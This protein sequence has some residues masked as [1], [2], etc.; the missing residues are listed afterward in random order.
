MIL[1]FQ[2]SGLVEIV[3]APPFTAQWTANAP[4]VGSR[5]RWWYGDGHSSN[6]DDILHPFDFRILHSDNPDLTLIPLLTSHFRHLTFHI[7]ARG[8]PGARG[9]HHFS[10]W[11]GQESFWLSRLWHQPVDP[12]PGRSTFLEAS[13]KTT[14]TTVVIVSFE[15]PST[16]EQ[17]SGTKALYLAS[18]TRKTWRIASRPC[19]CLL[20]LERCK[21]GDFK[22]VRTSPLGG[23]LFNLHPS[24]K[25]DG[26]QASHSHVINGLYD[27][28]RLPRRQIQRI[29]K[30]TCN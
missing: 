19:P 8:S 28:C 2:L 23:H 9:I 7:G 10:C 3:T 1:R 12:P 26:Q 6:D 17:I 15:A 21:L 24:G 25:Q 18:S 16:V 14:T 20:I 5:S 4:R 30:N 13:K 22:E 11:N 27:V 29:A